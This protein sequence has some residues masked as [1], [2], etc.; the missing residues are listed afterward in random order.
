MLM[1][2]LQVKQLPDDLH[3]AL[4]ARAA[5]EH[6]TMSDLV[7]QILRR[8]LAL[9]SMTQWL[10]RLAERPIEDRGIDSIAL[11]DAVRGELPPEDTAS[12]VRPTGAAS[13]RRGD[14]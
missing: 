7:T 11:L 4:K 6:V 2:T 9:P 3:A 12:S 1:A 8:E 13:H 14:R 10:A 5:Q